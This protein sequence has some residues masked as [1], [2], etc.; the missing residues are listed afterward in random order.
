MLRS[1]L[2]LMLLLALPFHASAATDEGQ[3]R[4][5]LE[6]LQADIQQMQTLLKKI[7]QQRNS[8]ESQLGKSEQEIGDLHRQIEQIEQRLQEGQQRLKKLQTDQRSLVSQINQQQQEIGG[9]IRS[10]FRSGQQPYLKLVLSQRDPQHSARMLHYFEYL[11]RAHGDQISEYRERLERL[12]QI[13]QKIQSTQLNL[14]Q[15]RDQQKQQFSRL[16]QQQAERKRLVATL[17]QTL[18]KKDQDL[19]SK[20]AQQ[21]ELKQILQSLQAAIANLSVPG[22]P[23]K[24]LR[25]KMAWPVKGKLSHRFGSSKGNKLRW[26]G[27]YISARAGSAVNAIH[28]GR[29]VFSDWLRGF[30]LLLIVDHGNDYLSLYAHN[31][32]LLKD[33]GEW[34]NAGEQIA[35]VGNSGGQQRNGLYFEVRY[36]GKPQN[37][38]RC[39][40][41]RQ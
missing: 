9:T 4:Q 20:Q 25:G 31:R 12:Q 11:N 41:A 35:T 32:S 38:L 30:G 21:A 28:H 5:Q 36:R 15:Q 26:N 19:A 23:F 8:A 29:V 40:L 18:K 1:T 3:T 22:K 24:Q 10:L 27:I 33:M 16:K 2:A 14:T 39:C 13:D 6:Q 37:P 17:K 7:R 34:V